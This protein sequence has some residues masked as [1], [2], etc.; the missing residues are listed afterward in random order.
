M[1]IRWGNFWL[2]KAGEMQMLIISKIRNLS[3]SNQSHKSNNKQL[4]PIPRLCE[5]IT[6]DDKQQVIWFD[7]QNFPFPRGVSDPI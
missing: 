4:Q 1:I 6:D 3:R 5:I 7:A 2:T